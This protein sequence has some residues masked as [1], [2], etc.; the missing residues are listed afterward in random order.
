MWYVG[1]IGKPSLNHYSAVALAE[2][3]SSAQEGGDG[4]R[5]HRQNYRRCG[6]SLTRAPLAFDNIETESRHTAMMLQSEV[7]DGM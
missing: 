7:I 3:R 4:W 2:N 1:Y 6:T 5:W